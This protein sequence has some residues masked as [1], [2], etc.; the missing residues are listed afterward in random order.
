MPLPQEELEEIK[1]DYLDSLQDLTINSRPLIRDLTIIAQE[2]LY[3]AQYIVK[4]VEEHI[5]RAPPSHKL[6]ALY[7]LDSICKNVGSPYTIYF[8]QNLSKIFINTYTLME[9]HLRM[10][11]EELLQTW[12]QPVPGTNSLTPVFSQEITRKIDGLLNKI[13]QLRL[14]HDQQ[15]KLQASKSTMIPSVPLNSVVDYSSGII[16]LGNISGNPDYIGN[17]HASLS[18]TSNITVNSLLVDISSLLAVAQKRVLLNPDDEIALKQ[19]PALIKLQSI[20]QISALPADQLYAIK[21]QLSALSLQQQ[22]N[23]LQAV[24]YYPLQASY[25]GSSINVPPNIQSTDTETLLA[26]LRS[27]G[28]LTDVSK[29]STN[30]LKS[31]LSLDPNNL[32]LSSLALLNNSLNTIELKSSS[33]TKHRPELVV[34]LYECMSLQCHTC[35]K[36]FEDTQ[37]GRKKRDAHL[38]WHFRINNRLRELSSRGQSR[39]WYF[40]EEEWIKYTHEDGSLITVEPLDNDLDKPKKHKDFNHDDSYVLTP[41]DP[42]AA[43][44]PCPICKEKFISVWN[45]DVEEWVWKNSISIEGVIYHANC[46][47]EASAASQALLKENTFELVVKNGGT[48][49]TVLGKRKKISE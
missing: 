34:L 14:Q 8:S 26:S 46:L 44:E 11:M 20:L 41:T 45:E 28:L 5:N 4:A 17:Q 49:N 16:N 38:D 15:R 3:A 42:N 9:P 32:T 25:I 21:E 22:Q 7:L 47:S 39:S 29:N 6:P 13:R 35:A 18:I 43:N 37:D 23:T 33:L 10:K 31:C 27:A 36:R 40:D 24:H 12:K 48:L 30:D 2:T 19:I 1:Q